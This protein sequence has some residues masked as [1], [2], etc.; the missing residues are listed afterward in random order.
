MVP[1]KIELLIFKLLAGKLWEESFVACVVAS[2]A[3]LTLVFVV[4][5]LRINKSV[6][7]KEEDAD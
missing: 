1:F 4:T 2:Q 7:D 6:D 5:P 3:L